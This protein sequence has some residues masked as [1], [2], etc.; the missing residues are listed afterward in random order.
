MLRFVFWDCDNTLVENAAL[1]WKKHEVTLIKHGYHLPADVKR[2]FYH[3]NGNQNWQWMVDH[4]GLTIPCEAYLKEVDAWYHANVHE[5]PFR[6]GI[7]WALDYFKRNNVK[8]CVVTNA[9]RASVEPMLEVK[10]ISPYFEFTWCKENYTARKPDPM[11]YLS[12]LENMERVMNRKVDKAECLAIEDD[13][14]GVTAAHLAGIPVIQ[15]RY[16]RDEFPSPDADISVFDEDDFIT[17][18]R[19]MS[20]LPPENL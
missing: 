10:G 17:A 8:Q 11:P 15:R 19:D 16:E 12:A 14:L 4:I 13:P 5:V 3:N 7:P 6:G 1:H 2:T 9:R 20:F 18:I